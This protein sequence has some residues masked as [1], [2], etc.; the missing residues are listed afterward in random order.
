MPLHPGQGKNLPLLYKALH[1]LR[2]ETVSQKDDLCM[3]N[4]D[5]TVARQTSQDLRGDQ[6][7]K[8]IGKSEEN[9]EYAGRKA[10]VTRDPHPL[11]AEA[12]A[13]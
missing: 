8:E 12:T 7:E 1:L 5:P 10:Q 13:L 3:V 2:F 6:V 4:V 11:V 9:Q